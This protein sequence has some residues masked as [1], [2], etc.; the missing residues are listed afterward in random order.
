MRCQILFTP[1]RF[2]VWTLPLVVLGGVTCLVTLLASPVA[3]AQQGDLQSRR[4][5]TQQRLN[6]LQEQIR[7]NKSRLEE[8]VESEE[9]TLERLKTLRRKIAV[10]GELV[11]TYQ[12]RLQELEEERTQLRDTLKTLETHLN[13]LREGYED[14]VRHAY[15]YNRLP[16]LALLLASRSINQMLVR[17]RYLQ[18]FAQQRKDQ[19]AEVQAATQ[20]VQTSRKQ[21]AQ[22]RKE[23]E[24]LLEEARIER[25]NLR[26]LEEDRQETIEALR[27]RRSELEA[28]LE[29]KQS[30]AR[31]LETQLQALSSKIARRAGDAS[32]ERT[33]AAAS[34]SASF[35]D[36][37]GRLP[38][39]TEGAVTEGFGNHTDPVHG[40]QTYH[41]GIFIATQPQQAVRAVFD[42]TVSD[43][44]F[45]PG[46]GTY[47]VVRHGDY[48]SVYSNFSTLS[49][50]E[51]NVVQAG[52]Q[53]GQAGTE[54]EPRG[55][56]LFFA[57]FDRSENTSVNPSAWLT[58]P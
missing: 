49:V 19:R 30:Q 12:R 27:S 22:T 47:L 31:R 33:E 10:R 13:D 40:T 17:A 18:R 34:L 37:R 55:A 11:E 52:Q 43:V 6:A 41:P 38:W 32:A 25:S 54:S 58:S 26:A 4:T 53:I 5:A 9:S 20:Q 36:N 45:I 46:Y 28:E 44:D 50:T 42:G 51:G 3:R 16:D 2:S 48:L 56:G 1:N 23:T 39:P 35:E 29:E 15:M 24:R 7:Q 57:V 8:T 21:L 14:R